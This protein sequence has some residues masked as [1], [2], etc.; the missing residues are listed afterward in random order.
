MNKIFFLLT[1]VIMLA[2]SVSAASTGDISTASISQQSANSPQTAQIRTT[3]TPEIRVYTLGRVRVRSACNI[4]LE[5]P[6]CKAG[7]LGHIEAGG[8]VAVTGDVIYT[9]HPD[10]NQWQGVEWRGDVGYVCAAWL[11]K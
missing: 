6:V 3:N 2:C 4:G 1:A 11:A 8:M 7:D 5:T 9:S 10:C